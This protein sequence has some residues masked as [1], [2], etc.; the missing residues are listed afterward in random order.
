M[1]GAAVRLVHPEVALEPPPKHGIPAFSVDMNIV[2]TVLIVA[3]LAGV[4][5]WA[6]TMKRNRTPPAPVVAVGAAGPITPPAP[7]AAGCAGVGTRAP[8]TSR[9]RPAGVVSQN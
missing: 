1:S 9:L 6:V 8:N 4:T 2:W 7:Q 5:W 3:A